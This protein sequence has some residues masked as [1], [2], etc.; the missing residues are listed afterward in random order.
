MGKLNGILPIEGTVGKITFTKTKDGIV[1]RE[2][3]GI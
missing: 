2:K 1:V 3:D